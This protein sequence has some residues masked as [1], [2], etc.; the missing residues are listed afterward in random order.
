MP[1]L[2][3]NNEVVDDTWI[4]YSDAEAPVPNGQ[5]IVSLA[6]WNTQKATLQSRKDIGLWLNSDEDPSMIDT[7]LNHFPVIAINFPAFTDGRGFSYGRE[8]REK[9]FEG[10]VRAIGSFIRDQL[11]YLKR[12]GFDSFALEGSDLHEAVK[13]LQ[14]FSESYQAAVDQTLPL[15]R[16]RA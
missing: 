7:D 2:I 1:Q 9:G 14:D 8:L 10:E 11:F 6:V 13:S 15:F 16:R 12:C 5:W 4:I 3:K